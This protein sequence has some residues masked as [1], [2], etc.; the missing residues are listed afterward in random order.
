VC[1]C[2]CVDSDAI[3]HTCIDDEWHCM[4]VDCFS[5]NFKLLIIG[6]NGIVLALKG[7]Q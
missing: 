2:V 7:S 6:S 4:S 1:V 5:L 3:P